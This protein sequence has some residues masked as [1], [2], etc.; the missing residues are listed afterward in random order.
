M[1]YFIFHILYEEDTREKNGNASSRIMLDDE[2][3]DEEEEDVGPLATR[4]K[5]ER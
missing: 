3:N 5:L 2:E 4:R 1:I